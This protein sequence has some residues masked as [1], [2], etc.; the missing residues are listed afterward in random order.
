MRQTI[1]GL[2]AVEAILQKQPERILHVYLLTKQGGYDR[3]SQKIADAIIEYKITHEFVS[4][5]KLDRLS[6]GG[7]HQGVVIQCAKAKSF[8]EAE[9]KSLI[10]NLQ[11]PALLLILDG[12]QDPHNLGACLRS[13]DAAGVHA[14][15]AP[16]D[17]SVGLTPTVNKVACGAV[18]T[19]PFVQVTNLART[20]SWL[21]EQGIWIFGTSDAADKTIYE[22]N[23]KIPTAFVLGNEEKGIRHLTKEYCDILLKIP[24]LGFVSSLNVSVA[25]GVYLFEAV[26][27][28]LKVGQVQKLMK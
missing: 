28:R 6:E 21:K 24:M 9:L 25:A 15:I 14:V 17:K 2:H 5:D 11:V 13:A 12:V 10:Q 20:L 22:E 3:R 27:Q 23:F 8:T 7:N 4:R 1:F 19:V 18:E 16:K 26:R